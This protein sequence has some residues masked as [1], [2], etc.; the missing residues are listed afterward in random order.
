MCGKTK[1]DKIINDNIRKSVG[2][3]PIV[4]KMVENK[5]LWFRNVERRYV[6][7]YVIRRVDQIKLSQIVRSR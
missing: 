1:H 3:T 2:V 7:D 6:D 5:L 4:K